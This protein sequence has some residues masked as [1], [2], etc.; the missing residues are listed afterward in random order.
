MDFLANEQILF[1]S[2]DKY[3]PIYEHLNNE[4]G[5]KYSKIFLICA[6]IGFKNN[7]LEEITG[8]GKEFRSTYLKAE[9]RANLYTIIINDCELGHQVE[10]F[11]N[12]EFINNCKKKI[13]RYAAGGMK[14]LVDNVFNTNWNGYNLDKNYSEYDID[15]MMY[16]YSIISEM[17]F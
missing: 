2:G 15:I 9:E 3:E 14:I 4:Y 12:K 1:Y 7:F 16:I 17:P 5:I 6:C 8:K 11:D 10:M 13:E